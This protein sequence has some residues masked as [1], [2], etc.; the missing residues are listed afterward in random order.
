VFVILLVLCSCNSVR[1]SLKSI[2]GNLLTY[3]QVCRRFHP[4]YS[5]IRYWMWQCSALSA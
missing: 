3:L 4:L 2:K 5:Y 1:M